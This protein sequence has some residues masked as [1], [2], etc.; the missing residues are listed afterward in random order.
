MRQLLLILAALSLAPTSWAGNHIFY[1]AEPLTA[2]SNRGQFS[3]FKLAGYDELGHAAIDQQLAEKFR[4]L[5]VYAPDETPYRIE[6]QV[7]EGYVGCD[8]SWL[9]ETPF[10]VT[11][12]LSSQRLPSQRLHS[13]A[14]DPAVIGQAREILASVLKKH[15]L[16]PRWI[17]RILGNTQAMPIASRAGADEFL[18]V[19]ANDEFRDRSITVFLLTR[20]NKA[21]RP[22]VLEERFSTGGPADSEAYAGT[23][24]LVLHGDLDGDGFEEILIK[25][26]AYESFGVSLLRWNGKRWETVG[27][28][29]GGC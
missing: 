20:K 10:P 14:T 17:L 27:G 22:V 1:N 24:E 28:N 21:G 25:T 15:R 12:L 4:K 2:I 6:A 3:G 7:K 29:G 13:P 9:I 18:A 19:A 26:D 5:W 11:G 23:L 16:S 8:Q